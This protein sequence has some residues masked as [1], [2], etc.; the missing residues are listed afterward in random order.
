LKAAAGFN[1]DKVRAA[2]RIEAI[3]LI[4]ILGEWETY[5]SLEQQGKAVDFISI[6][7]GQHILQKPQERFV[8]QQGNVDWFRYWLQ[9]Y[10]DPSPAK[11]G[12]YER[13]M[14]LRQ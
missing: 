13:W 9:G 1:L 2:V 14:K 11:R 6:P 10:I 8:S 12:Q 4:S 7:D 5:S 3:G